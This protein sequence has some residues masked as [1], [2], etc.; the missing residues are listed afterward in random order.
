MAGLCKP[1]PVDHAREA[2]ALR[3]LNLIEDTLLSARVTVETTRARVAASKKLIA[4]T[5]A[6]KRH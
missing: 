4:W 3:L 2:E 6:A 1:P 5:D